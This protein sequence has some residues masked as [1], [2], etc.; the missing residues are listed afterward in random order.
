[1][2]LIQKDKLLK[3]LKSL[4]NLKTRT[5]V[6]HQ[7]PLLPG[8]YNALNLAISYCQTKYYVVAGIDDYFFSDAI[9]E[10]NRS[11][12]RYPAIDILS[13]PVA[14]H[15]DGTSILP[16]MTMPYWIVGPRKFLSSH[17][18]GTVIRAGLHTQYGAYPNIY[19]IAGD[20]AFLHRI[21][22]SNGISYKY[23]HRDS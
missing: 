18:V 15:P 20:E 2:S 4:E 9:E 8:L 16:Q 10:I 14:S 17:S 23:V 6:Y 7:S 21:L 19:K 12:L 5:S 22:S 13:F 1:M 3:S 11:I